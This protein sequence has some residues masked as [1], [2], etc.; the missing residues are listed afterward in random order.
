VKRAR[1]AQI[2]Q[3]GHHVVEQDLL[4]PAHEKAHDR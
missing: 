3:T 1:Q 2:S 4:L